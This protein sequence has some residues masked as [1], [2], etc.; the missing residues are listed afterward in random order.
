MCLLSF[1][2]CTN[3]TVVYD[4]IANKSFAQLNASI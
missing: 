1:M 3:Y 4:Q 2:Q